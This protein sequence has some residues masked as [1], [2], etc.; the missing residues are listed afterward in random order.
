MIMVSMNQSTSQLMCIFKG[1]C[2]FVL[3]DNCLPDPHPDFRNK[4]KSI[5]KINLFY[6]YC[7]LFL[8]LKTFRYS[9]CNHD[10]DLLRKYK[11][12]KIHQGPECL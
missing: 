1:F 11:S 9:V 5:D 10:V 4:L 3:I 12:C 2:F 6:I 8:I 7:L